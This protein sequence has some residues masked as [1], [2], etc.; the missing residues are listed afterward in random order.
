ME[1]I[2]DMNFDYIII[3]AGSAGCVLAN[4]LSQDKDNSVLLI[5][6][7]S[8]DNN[9]WIHIP[10]G[11]GK[12]FDNPKV[13]WMY[14]SE[15]EQATG[16]RK[17]FQPR[18]KVIGGSS[19]ING[20]VYIRG[21]R[22]DF[23][24]W[25][26]ES[27]YGWDYNS[28]LP[29]F[30]KSEKNMDIH[31][32]YHGSDGEL[33]V[34]SPRDLYPLAKAFVKS[35]IN[36]GYPLNKDFNG[37]TQ[38]GF[39]HLQMTIKNGRRSSSSTAFLKS[40]RKR[41]NLKIYTNILISKVLFKNKT[42]IGVSGLRNGKVIKLYANREV[43]LS[44][45]SFNTPKILQLSGVGPKDVLDE[46]GIKNISVLEGVGKN[47]QDHY[48]GRIVFKTS[49]Q[50]TLNAVMKSKYRSLFEGLKYILFRRGFLNMGSSVS[51]G[52]I[53]SKQSLKRPDLH[54]S[55]ILFSGDKAGTMLHPWSG[56]S[57]IVRLLRPKSV[58]S[59][60]IK[61][62]DPAEQPQIHMNYFSHKNDRRLLVE[63]IKI[64]RKIL[65][66]DPIRNEC[67]EEY[68][69]GPEIISD[70]EIEQFLATKGGIS[71]HPVGTCKMGIGNDC[72]VD[73]SCSVYGV[74]NL[75]VV[76]ASIMP[77]ITSGNTNAPVIMIAEK[78]ADIILGKV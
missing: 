67:L 38:E 54:I 46:F 7:G 51:A 49:N 32:E 17:I 4:R 71:Y 5:E 21:Q 64:T 75:R 31:D 34:S 76:D 9:P 70:K 36:M 78:A 52:F 35:G 33:S 22:Q 65:R 11:Y 73:Y 44:A 62:M 10:L 58:G 42:A 40:I 59:L 23:D 12:H 61:S 3:G 14:H 29:Y 69:P 16:G 48:N 68:S 53:K 6:S 18:G 72:V 27:K 47:L 55:L 19:S 57:I 8:W 37:A 66:S 74:K 45:G 63:A 13:N 56:F 60:R 15:P 25:D 24:L 28:I 2:T 41:K 39:G 20:L 26:P 1:N 77:N 43:I 50:H 30:K